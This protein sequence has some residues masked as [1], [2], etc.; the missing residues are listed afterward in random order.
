MG[1]STIQTLDDI[2]GNLTPVLADIR[3]EL[4]EAS[5][6]QAEAEGRASEATDRLR[7]LVQRVKDYL[8]GERDPAVN[9]ILRSLLEDAL[10]EAEE[11]LP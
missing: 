8:D 2:I 5:E 11:A 10:H 3:N 1:R 9:R 6:K 4:D 7:L